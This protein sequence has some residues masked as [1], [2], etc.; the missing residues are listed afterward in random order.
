[1]V[2]VALLSMLFE[3]GF[4][5][6]VQLKLSLALGAFTTTLTVPDPV[7]AKVTFKPLASVNVVCA[8]YP[9][10][11]PRAPTMNFMFRS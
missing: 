4:G 8:V 9:E 10:V 5:V 2:P 6:P 11:N 7:P 3:H 1:M